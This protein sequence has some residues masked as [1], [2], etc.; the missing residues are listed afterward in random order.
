M[1]FA[2]F[3]DRTTP[4]APNEYGPFQGGE[5]S[6]WTGLAW[7]NY[8]AV[9]FSS[10]GGSFWGDVDFAR[11]YVPNSTYGGYDDW[12]LPSKIEA[13]EAAVNGVG[14][15]IGAVTLTNGNHYLW[16]T[17]TKSSGQRTWSVD[18]GGSGGFATDPLNTSTLYVAGVRDT[19]VAIDDGTPG[20]ANS[21][22]S[23]KAASGAYLGDQSSASAGNGSRTATWTFS[24]LEAGATYKVD[25]TWKPVNGAATNAP[26]TVR[27]GSTIV[28]TR[29]LNEGVAPNDFTVGTTSWEGLGT[30]TISG[31][32]LSVKLTNAA[33]GTV[34][35]DAVRIFKV[36]PSYAPAAPLMAEGSPPSLSVFGP[37]LSLAD[38][39]PLLQEVIHRW[40]RA[41]ADTSS[42]GNVQIQIANLGGMTLGLASGNIITLDDDAA[43]WGWFVDRTPRSDSEFHR[44]GDQG[45]QNHMDLLTVLV[46]EVGHLLGH[47]HTEG[48]VMSGTLATGTRIVAPSGHMPPALSDHTLP[49]P[50]LHL[51]TGHKLRKQLQ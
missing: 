6:F 47:E 4:V 15:R 13:Q 31:S 35:A 11:T 26:F 46:H 29:A 25:V 38:A 22:F 49:S 16:W 36:L 12:R 40:Q 1:N 37:A 2:N 3:L 8:S 19:G 9:N 42:L 39:R 33:N 32:T 24:G 14:Q 21:G 28:G 17:S 27:D 20:Y 45:E 43:G 30:Y 50:E 41:G 5:L 10:T 44:K 7:V 48:G 51:G 18:L 23:A 34:I